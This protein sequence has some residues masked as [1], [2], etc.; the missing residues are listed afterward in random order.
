MNDDD[1][2]QFLLAHALQGLCAN[3]NVVRKME[4]ADV[5]AVAELAIDMADALMDRE[6]ELAAYA[7][8]RRAAG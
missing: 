4:N 3:P 6:L 8:K 1:L 7:A 5:K 2:R